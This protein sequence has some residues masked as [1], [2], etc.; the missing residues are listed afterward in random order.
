MI[1]VAVVVVIILIAV[2]VMYSKPADNLQPVPA[3][4][5]NAAAVAAPVSAAETG[6]DKVDLGADVDASLAPVDAQIN[7][8]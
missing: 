2:G 7:S 4:T 5:E 3:T 1:V 6:V 8:L